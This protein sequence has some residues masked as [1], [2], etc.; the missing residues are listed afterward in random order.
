MHATT[1]RRSLCRD[2]CRAVRR[3]LALARHVASLTPSG[4]VTIVPLP[5]RLAA[6]GFVAQP[7]AALSS[8]LREA[9][10]HDARVGATGTDA[11][12]A[13]T[14]VESVLAV[15]CDA[16]RMTT[17]VTTALA[18]GAAGARIF[19]TVQD[20]V[21]AV[22]D[23]ELPRHECL[24]GG[25]RNRQRID[26]FDGDNSPFAYL[27]PLV[28]GGKTLFFTT[29]NGAKGVHA[30]RSARQLVL[31]SFVNIN[32]VAAHV[33][34]ALQS[35]AA[36]RAAAVS[37]EE[38]PPPPL[39]V[40]LLSSGTVGERSDEDDLFAG[41]LLDL[42]LAS[43]LVGPAHLA[44]A[45]DPD[46]EAVLQWF[47]EAQANDSAAASAA[48]TGAGA[49]GTRETRDWRTICR[50]SANAVGLREVGLERDID[51]TLDVDR[52]D[53]VLPVMDATDGTFRV[54]A[55]GHGWML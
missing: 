2:V 24:L 35:V 42:L 50:T 15:V 16:Q 43:E 53:G 34:L 38:T 7:L 45:D 21:D 10:A 4:V 18:S 26:G 48:V 29:T 6:A 5:S 54:R 39:P 22:R 37:R 44:L 36:S 25:E 17:T 8:V 30:T 31:G 1:V 20:T 40:L 11:A 47:R 49:R 19:A 41:M 9:A 12:A 23:S 3:P 52:F 32:T 46:T 27:D 28:V 33:A 55:A 14:P 13:A 51:F